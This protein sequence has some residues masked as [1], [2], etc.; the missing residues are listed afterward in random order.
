MLRSTDPGGTA[1]TAPGIAAGM[2]GS[3]GMAPGASKPPGNM[4]GTAPGA[5][6]AANKGFA[7]ASKGLTAAAAAAPPD[8]GPVIPALVASRLMRAA[9]VCSNNRMQQNDGSGDV[10]AYERI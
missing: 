6:A 4:V 2:P 5:A 1:P 7:A 8:A 10:A 3:I 9:R